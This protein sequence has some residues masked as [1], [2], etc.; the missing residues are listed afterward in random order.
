MVF[1]CIEERA[2]LRKSL[3]SAPLQPFEI[4]PKTLRFWNWLTLANIHRRTNTKIEKTQTQ[5]ETL[6]DA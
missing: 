6:K 1:D 5:T 3:L 4:C 2:T